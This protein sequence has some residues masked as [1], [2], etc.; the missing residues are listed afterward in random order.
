MAKEVMAR[1][2]RH[3]QRKIGRGT[4][5]KQEAG[6]KKLT[7]EKKV[8]FVNN[9]KKGEANRLKEKL[10]E[11]AERRIEDMKKEIRN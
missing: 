1:R 3:D 8:A 9:K 10:R 2:S 11:I 7:E 4:K 5:A 6:Q